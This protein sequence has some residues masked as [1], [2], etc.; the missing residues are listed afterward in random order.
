MQWWL[1]CLQTMMGPLMASGV[2]ASV[3]LR[4]RSGGGAAMAAIA[5]WRTAALCRQ[6]GVRTSCARVHNIT[7]MWDT[8]EQYHTRM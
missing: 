5:V 7:D 2:T 6:P 8:S 3:L 4:K 1:L